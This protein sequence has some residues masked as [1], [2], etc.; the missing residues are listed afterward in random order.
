LV[1]AKIKD[2][3]LKSPAEAT[4]KFVISTAADEDRHTTMADFRLTSSQI[5]DLDAGGHTIQEEGTPLTQRANLNFIGAGITATDNLGNDATD[6]TLS[7]ASTDLT[8]TSNIAYLDAANTFTDT[9]DIVGDGSTKQVRIARYGGSANVG[10]KITGRGAEGTLASPTANVDTMLMSVDGTSYDGSTFSPAARIRMR[11][12]GASSSGSTPGLIEISTTPTGTAS[13]VI[14]LTIREDGTFNF[15]TVPT[16]NFNSAAITNFGLDANGT[17]NS[18]TN[19]DVADHSATGTPDATT[20][21]RGDN[22]W[23]IPAGGGSVTDSYTI[24]ATLEVPEGTVAYPDIHTLATAGAKVSGFVMPDGATASTINFKCVVPNDLN[25][26][27]AMAIRVRMM[28]LGAVAGPADVRLTVSTVGIADGE[29]LDT[30]LTAETEVTVTMPT[31]TET[32]DYHSQDLTSD[33][34]AADTIIGQIARDPTDASDD[35]TDDIMIIGVDLVTE[36]TLS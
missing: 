34:A 28:T 36:R 17:G 14:R 5:T 15:N 21:Y 9:L 35:F 6:V 7:L 11:P 25:V 12:D 19:I 26:T 31:A 3:V 10:P 22:T 18:I 30:A 8:D 20:F 2:I 32:L 29:S 23:A 4:D 16:I 27:P 1:D 33:W 24:P 13:E